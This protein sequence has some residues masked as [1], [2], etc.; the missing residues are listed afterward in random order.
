MW[1]AGSMLRSA[2]PSVCLYQ[3]WRADDKLFPPRR[4]PPPPPACAANYALM[5][6]APALGSFGLAMGLAGF[7]YEVSMTVDRQA[8]QGR[9]GRASAGDQSIRQPHPWPGPN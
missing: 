5:Q 4:P 1:P 2:L 6:L 3:E 7:L 9:A 8:G